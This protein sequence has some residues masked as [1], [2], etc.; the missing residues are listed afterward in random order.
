[1]TGWTVMA[2]VDEVL[3]LLD[4]HA[5]GDGFPMLDNGYV[6]LAATRLS[7]H[8]SPSDWA[9]VIEVFGYS[10]RAG[11][12]DVTVYTLTGSDHE[13]DFFYPIDDDDWT[14]ADDVKPGTSRVVLRGQ[15]VELPAVEEY[16]AHGIDLEAPQPAVIEVCRYLAAVHRDRVLATTDERR[17]RLRPDLRELLV[18]DEW[19]HPDLGD[20][21][22]SDLES[23]WQLAM[24]LETGDVT[25]YQPPEPPNTHWRH[26]PE[27]GTL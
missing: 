7:L 4:E 8:R 16:A 23:F 27:G 13:R 10:V 25:L 26:W 3:A 15:S 24:V 21:R 12:P 19:R 11:I 17:T 5:L 9:M 6:Y 18:L 22:P 1:M 2:T 14:D 20:E